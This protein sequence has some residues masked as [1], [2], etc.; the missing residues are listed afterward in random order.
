MIADFMLRAYVMITLYALS[1]TR[2]SLIERTK[3]LRSGT[4]PKSGASI[5]AA[6]GYELDEKADQE[7][8]VAQKL[9]EKKALGAA[10][11]GWKNSVLVNS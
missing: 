9:A 8:L 1:K 2:E 11:A 10:W 5:E 6:Q 3:A 7:A 4:L